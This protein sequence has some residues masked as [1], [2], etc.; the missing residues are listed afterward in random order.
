MA[1]YKCIGCG[2][3]RESETGCTCPYCGY[4]MYP[5]PYNRKQVLAD[6]INRFVSRLMLD[7]VKADEIKYF[8]TESPDKESSSDGKQK[9]ISKEDD[10]Q[11]FPSFDKIQTYICSSKKTEEFFSRLDTSL[12]K[13]KEHI[14]E[15]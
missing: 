8:R 6:E 14:H 3:T 13:L 4:R 11:R 10:D 5:A 7:E 1:M 9:V 2:Q 12:E 15:P